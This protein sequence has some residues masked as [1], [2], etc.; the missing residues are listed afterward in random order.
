V[1]ILK[2]NFNVCGVYCSKATMFRPASVL[3][4]AVVI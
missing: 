2:D 4:R 1:H 3:F